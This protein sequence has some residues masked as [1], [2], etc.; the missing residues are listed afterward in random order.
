MI[1]P[2]DPLTRRVETAD[3]ANL[4]E[5]A[6]ANF[7]A[8]PWGEGHRRPD[9]VQYFSVQ[10][11]LFFLPPRRV[12]SRMAGEMTDQHSTF[13]RPGG[14]HGEMALFGLRE[15]RYILVVRRANEFCLSG[16]RLISH[17]PGEPVE[18][19]VNPVQAFVVT[20]RSLVLILKISMLFHAANL[21]WQR[22]VRY[23]VFTLIRPLFLS[24]TALNGPVPDQ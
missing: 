13:N 16:A 23:G 14:H 19:R 1:G 10:L 4:T 7:P 17:L 5:K 11:W 8:P 24:A 6:S 15:D 21:G 2:V 3:D 22:R 9:E 12:E 20:V 18:A